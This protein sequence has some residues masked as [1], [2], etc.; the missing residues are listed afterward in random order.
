[1]KKRRLYW[2]LPIIIIVVGIIISQ[3]FWRS[4]DKKTIDTKRSRPIPVETIKVSYNED[5]SN[6]VAITG[7]TVAYETLLVKANTTGTIKKINFSIGSYIEKGD[8][9]A[10]LDTSEVDYNIELAAEEYQLRKKHMDSVQQLLDKGVISYPEYLRYRLEYLE[11]KQKYYTLMD[12]KEKHY[13]VSPLSGIVESKLVSEGEFVMQKDK[14]AVAHDIHEIK[15]AFYMDE[16]DYHIFKKTQDNY[17]EIYIPALDKTFDLSN[18]QTAEVAQD[19]NHSIYIEACIPNPEHEIIPGLFVNIRIFMFK[20]EKVMKVPNSAV[21]FEGSDYFVYVV[22]DN[23]AKKVSVK[24]GESSNESV[25]ILAGINT[26]DNIIISGRNRLH[27][28]VKVL[29]E[30]V[31]AETARAIDLNEL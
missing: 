12:Q 29:E 17:A 6:E 8:V 15:I 4:T 3:L 19:K 7:K 25:E 20:K 22:K 9:L 11:S 16:N 26:G 14:I 28:G 21:F 13:I 24:I 1:M 18:F 31:T 23:I 30:N 10:V 5:L 27:G 2:L